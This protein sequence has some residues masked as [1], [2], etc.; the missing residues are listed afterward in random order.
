MENEKI[1]DCRELCIVYQDKYIQSPFLVKDYKKLCDSKLNFEK[2]IC[3]LY[4]IY[5]NLKNIALISINEFLKNI[6]V[7]DITKHLIEKEDFD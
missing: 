5:K 1:C 2:K 4:D 3:P 6:S 7:D